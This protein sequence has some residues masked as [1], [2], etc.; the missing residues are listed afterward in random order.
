MI[1]WNKRGIWGKIPD[2]SGLF[3]LLANETTTGVIVY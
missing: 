3:R 2:T 1:L